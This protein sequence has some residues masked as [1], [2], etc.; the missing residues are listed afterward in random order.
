MSTYR[1]LREPRHE[2]LRIR[3]L[4]MH[5][6][7]LGPRAPRRRAALAAAARLSGYGRHVSVPGGCIRAR[8]AADGARLARLR[9]QRAGGRTATG[10][11]IISRTSTR[12]SM[13]CAATGRVRLVGHSM[14]GNIASLYAG[15]RPQRVRSLVNLEGF[16][17]PR[18]AP[19]RAPAQLAK[20]LDQ[21][22]SIPP[23]KD[24]ESFDQL[25]SIIRHRYPRFGEARA[26]VRRAAPGADSRRTG[27]CICS[28]I[29]G[30][31]GST[32][33]CTS[34]R[35]P[36]RAGAASARPCSWSSASSRI[37]CRA[38]AR[39]APKDAMRSIIHDVEIAHVAGA[40]HML[41]IEQPE[42]IARADRAVLEH[43]L[44]DAHAHPAN[45]SHALRT[46]ARAQPRRQGRAF[47]AA[48]SL[49]ALGQ[50]WE[51]L[52]ERLT[53]PSL[54]PD[55]L[56]YGFSDAP[57]WAL[58]LEQY[59]QCTADAIEA[60]GVAGRIRRARR[61]RRIARGD[62][63]R[64]RAC[65]IEVRRVLAVGM[66]LF[67]AEEQQRQMEKYSEQP[68]RP[69]IEGR[70]RAGGVARMLRVS[71]A[72]LRSC[73]CAAALRR[74][75]ARRQSRRRAQSGRRATRSRSG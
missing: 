44:R 72:A 2:T 25:A 13:F 32:R 23:L 67:T 56:G 74:A 24:Y 21:V 1:V 69:A 51:P 60:A 59:A 41:H 26:R 9:P 57:P 36:R 20:W 55:R 66:P 40:G 29:R 64:A 42:T 46:T 61:S 30:I 39:T 19:D 53:R 70:T 6:A 7:Q 15:V 14:G 5:A 10:S 48:A 12:S 75:L 11:T 22:K 4:D 37:I 18:T 58:S 49:A 34:A 31:A 28:A 62:R 54:A 52:Q 43:P 68:L 38:S 65:R 8:L 27:G 63:D 33:R 16:G 17:M 45:L 47:A 71:P 35:M 50:M 73:R 3:G